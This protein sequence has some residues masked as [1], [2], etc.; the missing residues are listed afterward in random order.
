MCSDIFLHLSGERHR[1]SVKNAT[2]GWTRLDLSTRPPR[3]AHL[4]MFRTKRAIANLKSWVKK[5]PGGSLSS[6]EINGPQ[7]LLTTTISI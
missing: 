3:C 6:T 2:R 4:N 5:V 1:F 7:E